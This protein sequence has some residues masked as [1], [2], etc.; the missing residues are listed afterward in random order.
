MCGVTVTIILLK[1]LLI[2]S[3]MKENGA[4]EYITIALGIKIKSD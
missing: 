4:Q 1:L 2:S 3:F